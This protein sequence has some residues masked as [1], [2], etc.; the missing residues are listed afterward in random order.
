M[1]A[2]LSY[3]VMG[4][5]FMLALYLA[6]R[7]FLAR[8]NQHGF[9]RGVL[10]LIYLVSFSMPTV[11]PM[12]ESSGA[13]VVMPVATENMGIAVGNVAAQPKPAWGAILFWVFLTGMVTVAAKTAF[14]WFQLSVV[15]RK[16]KKIKQDGYTLVVTE[17]EKYA[18]FSWMRYIVISRSDCGNNCPAITAHELK[19]IASHH[20]A[21]L[22]IAQAVCIINWFNP[23]AWLVRDE[24]MLVHEYEADMAVLDN[25]HDPQEYQMLLIKKAVGSRFPSLA[26]SLN[27]SKLKKR[28]T[29][30]Y[31]SKSGAG[32]KFKALALV[33][34]VA[35]ALGL[36]S[37]PAVRAAVSAIGSI[38]IFTDKGS[39]NSPQNNVAVKKFKVT[40]INN[41]GIETTVTVIGQGLGDHLTVSGGTFTNNGRT[42]RAKSMSCNTTD[43]VANITVTFPFSE[44]YKNAS[45]T[46]TVNGEE[47]PFNLEDFRNN[48]Q[49]GAVGSNPT[50]ADTIDEPFIVVEQ[51][52]TFQG[53]D[54]NKFLNWVAM[55]LRYPQVAM[56][57][58]ISGR[59]IVNFVIERDGSL[60]NI[61]VLNT[62]DQ[63]LSDEAVRVLKMSPKWTPGR[64][65]S[66]TVRVSYNLPVD[67]KIQGPPAAPEKRK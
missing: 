65:G 3:S 18:P 11:V 37:V 66:N 17:S 19:H 23:A 39:E 15:I 47:I 10:L 27:H 59:V 38:A 36:V 57:N 28:I 56:E 8:E 25:G 32:R 52:P 53:G 45:M 48:A 67:F 29:M 14:T 4:G 58:G 5:L 44:E 16:G 1:G 24:L 42:Y 64:Q 40:N 33:P 35:L 62:P 20:W 41:N 22:L 2:L 26:N 60:T 51:M 50:P 30:M 9:N 7:V 54:L 6:Y 13:S 63:C 43:G 55:N 61:K 21:D 12:A 49:S 31:K 46:L 34:T